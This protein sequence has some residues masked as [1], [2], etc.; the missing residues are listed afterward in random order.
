MY[1][2]NNF[3]LSLAKKKK[4]NRKSYLYKLKTIEKNC[5][6]LVAFGGLGVKP[7]E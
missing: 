3:Y 6:F 2:N 7:S 1:S 4:E 5:C